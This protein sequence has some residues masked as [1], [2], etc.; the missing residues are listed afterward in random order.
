MVLGWLANYPADQQI[1]KARH[2]SEPFPGLLGHVLHLGRLYVLLVLLPAVLFAGQQSVRRWLPEWAHSPWGA[3]GSIA[4]GLFLLTLLPLAFKPVLGLKP[5]PPTLIRDRLERLAQRLGI[6]FR[7]MLLWRMPGGVANAMVV[8]LVAPARYCIFSDGILREL[9]VEELEGVL[10]HEAGHVKHKH[11]GFYLLFFLLSAAAGTA[12]ILA[13]LKLL[14]LE[15]IELTEDQL[16]AVLILPS[17][18]MMVYAF[19]VFGFVSRMCE[20]QADV[21]ACRAISC[22]D[23]QCV[24]HAEPTGQT[25]LQPMCP[26]GIRLFVLALENVQRVNGIDGGRGGLFGCIL[27][28]AKSWQHGPIPARVAFLRSLIVEPEREHRF[29]VRVWRTKL[30][31][32]AFLFALLAAA[33]SYVG[34]GKVLSE[35]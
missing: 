31:L 10:G 30:V 22:G 8:G 15:D 21:F 26:T 24:V 28:W 23:P 16:N 7:E 12:C 20:R 19:V 13:L 17:L 11:V 33:G 25:G 14:G 35:L 6:R 27:T 18:L 1:H 2:S 3:L 4:A 5:L 34:W 32:L 9:S 29:Q